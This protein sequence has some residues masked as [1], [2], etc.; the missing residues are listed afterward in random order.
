MNEI[1]DYK[2]PVDL[3]IAGRS[4]GSCTLCCKVF[5]VPWIDE[6]PAGSWCKHCTPG[7][8]CGIWQTRPQKCRDFLCQYFYIPEMTEEWRPDRA[9]FLVHTEINDFILMIHADPAQPNAWKR[10]P[11][12]SKIRGIA[13]HRMSIGKGVVLYL[14]GKKFII[15][16]DSEVQID[17]Y[18]LTTIFQFGKTMQNGKPHYHINITPPAAS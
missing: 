2:P 11:Y 10:E 9:K 1:L 7:K 16:P 14:A 6:K 12:G 5:P 18:P 4:C 15:T 8:G 17:Q 13:A 3:A